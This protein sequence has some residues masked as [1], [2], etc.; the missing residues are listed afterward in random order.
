MDYGTWLY[1]PDTD[2]WNTVAGTEPDGDCFGFE[3]TVVGGRAV[4]LGA[5][6]HSLILCAK[7]FCY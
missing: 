1:R 6:F 3:M 5:E 4:A 2:E 7:I